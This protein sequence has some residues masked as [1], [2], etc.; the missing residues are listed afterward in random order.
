MNWIKNEVIFKYLKKRSKSE[1]DVFANR[2]CYSD[3]FAHCIFI[4]DHAAWEI[5]NEGWR[6]E[7]CP[8]KE[9]EKGRLLMNFFY[10]NRENGNTSWFKIFIP[11]IY[12]TVG[13]ENF[14]PYYKVILN[15]SEMIGAFTNH[16]L[17]MRTLMTGKA[18]KE[19]II[20]DKFKKIGIVT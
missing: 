7:N 8:P 3:D 10:Y 20:E 15:D 5:E 2:I 14:G 12:T 18:I 4:R 1:L 9:K 13:V 17:L 16:Y 6:N 19:S 11:K